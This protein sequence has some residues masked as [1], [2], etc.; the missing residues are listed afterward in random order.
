MNNGSGE[1]N[2]RGGVIGGG[3]GAGDGDGGREEGDIVRSSVVC[4]NGGTATVE[5][6]APGIPA[7]VCTVS[8]DG[9]VVGRSRELPTWLSKSGE[10]LELQY[11]KGFKERTTR[12]HR[13][14]QRSNGT[15]VRDIFYIENDEEYQDFLKCI[16]GSTNYSRGLLQVCRE[17]GHIHVAH[18]CAFSSGVCRCAWWKKAETYGFGRRRAK[19]GRR[20][21]SCRS[22]TRAGLEMLQLY[23]C[24]KGRK[25]VYQ[26]IGDKVERIP[27][28]GCNLQNEGSARLIEA[29]GE[30]VETIP[31]DRNQ[32]QHWGPSLS[33]D[34]PDQ[35]ADEQTPRRK[36]RRMGNTERLQLQIV[37]TCRMYPICPPIAVVTQPFWL[38]DD[39]LRFKTLKDREVVAAIENYSG[40]MNNWSMEDYQKLYNAPNCKPLFSSAYGHFEDVYYNLENS[41]NIMD[42]LIQFQCD[43]DDEMVYD[44][45]STLYNVLERKVPKLNCIVVHSPSSAGK[46]FL[47]DAIRDYYINTGQ[48]TTANK[49]DRFAFMEMA[50]RRL[51]FWNEP[52]YS[53][54]FLDC[55]KELLG[56]DKTVV[57][58]KNDRH[59]PVFRTPVIC[60]TNNIVSFMT[61]PCFADRVK[62]FNWR[63][64]PYL[65]D[66]KKKPNPL[67]TY[68][69]FKKYKLVV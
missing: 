44:F 53:P 62:V 9:A 38:Q 19:R 68:E 18:D 17:D 47:F 57:Q 51:A 33:D 25:I 16:R 43:G 54:E 48:I 1:E 46:N 31:G 52:N 32:L 45:V 15:L 56:G 5:R 13:E 35:T 24:T 22:R 3:G 69:L 2:I 64:A 30:V 11:F 29:I 63:A 37:D 10:D 59:M 6:D 34:E 14:L 66:Y 4:D 41:V 12:I 55:L 8:E 21:D 60:L 28:Q 50:R 27:D 58:V 40:Q 7:R 61:D 26:K 36:R 39:D 67:A 65:V 20:R 23:Y 49:H 42:E